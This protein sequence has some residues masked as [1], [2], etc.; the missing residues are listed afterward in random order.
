MKGKC[1][2]SLVNSFD[3][4]RLERRATDD[5]SVKN[6]ANRPSINLE[7]VTVGGIEEHFWSYVI[8]CPTNRLLPLP[9]VFN[10][11]SQTKVSDLNVHVGIQ[12]DIAEL[13]IP[14]DNLVHVHVVACT[15]ELNHEETGL[16]FGEPASTAEHI[17]QGAV[18]TKLKGHIDVFII[19]ETVLEPDD[20]RVAES[21]VNL[22]FCV[23]L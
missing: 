10:Q 3:I 14:V 1:F 6:D 7:A 22:D 13:E 12:E 23:E 5:K 21:T 18:M 19:F 8:W 20:V 9:G 16:W 11:C 2:N 4:F 17:H 15:N